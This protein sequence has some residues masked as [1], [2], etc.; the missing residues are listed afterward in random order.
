[1]KKN[2]YNYPLRFIRQSS[3]FLEM[4]KMQSNQ[5]VRSNTTFLYRLH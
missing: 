5:L 4:K 1:M 3:V 2:A